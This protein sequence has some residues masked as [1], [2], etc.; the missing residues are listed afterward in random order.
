M[1]T[2]PMKEKTPQ[3]CWKTHEK[4]LTLTGEPVLEVNMSWPQGE[5]AGPLVRSINR[6][7]ARLAQCWQRHWEKEG[8]LCAC[9]ALAQKREQSRP[10][11]PWTASLS[12][13][14]TL[15]NGEY[16]SIAMLA[17]EVHGDGR[18]LE[19]RWG[20]TWLWQ[21]GAPVPLRSLFPGEKRWRRQLQN[22]L[23]QAVE[24]SRRSG[25]YLDQEIKKPLRCWFSSSRYA[26]SPE[27]LE[28]YYPQCTLAPAVEGAP[29]F[30]L[31]LPTSVSLPEAEQKEA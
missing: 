14:V 23:E 17:R 19:Y 3:I 11:T 4:T 22:Q 10:F 13:Q 6:H 20:D 24:H 7:Y 12:G 27:G 31:P 2:L 5:G 8:Y 15:D 30:R 1:K 18:T 25:A 26:L 9:A 28:V 29:V 16:L 21:D